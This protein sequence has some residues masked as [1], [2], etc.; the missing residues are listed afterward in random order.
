MLLLEQ[1]GLGV[2]IFL[3]S[4]STRAILSAPALANPLLSQLG[5]S[6]GCSV[7]VNLTVDYS[8]CTNFHNE[9]RKSGAGVH[10]ATCQLVV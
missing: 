9:D 7:C 3:S 1:V 10:A 6:A 2:R 8:T 5:V 4:L